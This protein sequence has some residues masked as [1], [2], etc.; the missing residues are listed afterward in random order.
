[1]A[2][3][4]GAMTGRPGVA[5]VTRGPGATNASIGVHVAMQDS[6]PMVLFIGDIAR[7]TR[8]REAFQEIDFQAMFGPVA[9]WAARIDDAARIPEYVARAWN[10][11]MSGRPGPVVL[12]LPKDT[13]LDES[14]AVDRSRLERIAQ[15]ADPET[16]MTLVDL[17]K[18]ACAPVAI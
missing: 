11:A 7:D 4:D 15:P 8:D 13:L 14:N 12:A 1:M 5:F 17:L 18:G 2:C 6:V 3:G 10:T 16:M 9:K